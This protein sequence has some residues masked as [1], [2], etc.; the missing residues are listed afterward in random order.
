VSVKSLLYVTLLLVLALLFV[1][2][3]SLGVAVFE[4]KSESRASSTAAVEGTQLQPKTTLR[5]RLEAERDDFSPLKI[6]SSG[7]TRRSKGRRFRAASCDRWKSREVSLGS[8]HCLGPCF[9]KSTGTS[10]PR[11]TAASSYRR[12][13]VTPTSPPSA[14]SNKLGLQ[15]SH[16]WRSSVPYTWKSTWPM[17]RRSKRG[18]L[19][20]MVRAPTPSTTSRPTGP[21]STPRTV[22]RV[23]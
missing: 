3:P 5:L 22:V 7:A 6:G 9:W 8:D 2:G 16:P 15:R 4:A 21:R 17:T 1:Y 20:N 13:S 14:R 19:R 12:L 23:W 11:G 10:P 18:R